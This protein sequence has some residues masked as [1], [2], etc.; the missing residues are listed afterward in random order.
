MRTESQPQELEN[1]VLAVITVNFTVISSEKILHEMLLKL[2]VGQYV[3][4][5]GAL[6]GRQS[7][8]IGENNELV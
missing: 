7:L 4:H 8:F 1:V 6:C 5:Y 3:V 2:H